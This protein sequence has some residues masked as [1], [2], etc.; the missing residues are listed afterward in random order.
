MQYIDYE[1][2][3]NA[4]NL[5]FLIKLLQHTQ[6]TIRSDLLAHIKDDDDIDLTNRL[7]QAHN[8]IDAALE[9]LC[10]TG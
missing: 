9:S 3:T 4:I 10:H 5:L 2:S 8:H 7:L 1:N 6:Q